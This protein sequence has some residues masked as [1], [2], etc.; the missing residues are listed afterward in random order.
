M[1]ILFVD[2]KYNDC[3]GNKNEDKA[4]STESANCDTVLRNTHTKKQFS[5]SNELKG[6]DTKG[7]TSKLRERGG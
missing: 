7:E 1:R 3:G 2:V 5:S 4:E 6:K